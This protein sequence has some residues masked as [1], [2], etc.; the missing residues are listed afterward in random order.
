MRTLFK[1]D[2]NH[3][4][5]GSFDKK[6]KIWDF[7]RETCVQTLEGH[8]SN[9]L[10]IIKHEDKLISCPCDR[11]IKIWEQKNNFANDGQIYY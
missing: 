9:V 8:M 3:F 6:I 1:I 5:S 11:T 2:E 4:A 7:Q 10:C